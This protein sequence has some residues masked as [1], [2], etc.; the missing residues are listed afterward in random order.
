MNQEKELFLFDL[1]GV[2][3]ELFTFE[4]IA[5]SSAGLAGPGR[6][7]S[8]EVTLVDLFLDFLFDLGIGSSLH[9]FEGSTFGVPFGLG[10]LELLTGFPV[11]VDFEVGVFFAK[12]SLSKELFEGGGVDTDDGVFGEGVGPDVLVIGGVVDDVNDFGDEGD[13]FGLPGEVTG[14]ESEGSV[15]V[16]TASDSDLSDFLFAES[17]VGE[18]SSLFEGSLFLVDRHS[19][20]GESSFV[21]AVSRNSHASFIN[22]LVLMEGEGLIYG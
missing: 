15:L 7:A 10:F 5:I 14:V 22:V 2:E 18:R 17:G 3:I 13:L 9:V 6:N 11:E 1:S 4:E 19:P 21:S 20:T 12:V 8:I 16:V